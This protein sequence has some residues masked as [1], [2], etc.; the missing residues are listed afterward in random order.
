MEEAVLSQGVKWQVICWGP[1]GPSEDRVGAQEKAAVWKAI[2]WL[3]VLK[4]AI[5]IHLPLYVFAFGG[6]DSQGVSRLRAHMGPNE[7]PYFLS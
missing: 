6:K 5:I 7:G 2:R 3:G 4:L 1:W